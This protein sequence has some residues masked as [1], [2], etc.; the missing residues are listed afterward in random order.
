LANLSFK[1]SRKKKHEYSYFSL[2]IFWKLARRFGYQCSHHLRNNLFTQSF[3]MKVFAIDPGP[4]ESAYVLWDGASI[5]DKAKLPNNQVLPIVEQAG[6]DGCHMASEMIASYGMAVGVEVFET[7]V[8]IGR[9]MER[10]QGNLERIKRMECKLHI[11]HSVKAN[12]SNIRQALID[13][14]G[15]PG[16]KNE[17]GVTFGLVKDLWAA[18]AVAVTVY[19]K[20]S[21]HSQ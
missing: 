17:P 16:K 7:C 4:L 12:D 20:H 3:G 10:L 14:F 1:S 11:C 19:D 13:R 15:P 8:W 18:F 21:S 5:L 9:Y 6:K 2:R